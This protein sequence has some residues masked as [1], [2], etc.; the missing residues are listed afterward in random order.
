MNPHTRIYSAI[1]ALLWCIYTIFIFF[2][3]GCAPFEKHARWEEQR[4]AAFMQALRNGD[5]A[6]SREILNMTNPYAAAVN[7]IAASGPALDYTHDMIQRDYYAQQLRNQQNYQNSMDLINQS[8]ANAYALQDQLAQA[9]AAAWQARHQ[10]PAY[11]QSPIY[12]YDP[13]AHYHPSPVN[14]YMR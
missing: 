13:G 5:R 2:A 8:T 12:R 6:R 9:H 3:S 4:H 7:A 1:H 14:R 10:T 11:N